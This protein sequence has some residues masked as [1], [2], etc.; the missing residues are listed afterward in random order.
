MDLSTLEPMAVTCP[1]CGTDV[2]QRLYGPCVE[3]V[4]QLHVKFPGMAR[5]IETEDYVP[6]MNVTPNAI[7][8]KE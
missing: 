8:T 2:H 1:R 4:T 5:E 7:A 3:C 6:K